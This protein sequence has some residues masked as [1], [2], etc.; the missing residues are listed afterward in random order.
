MVFLEGIICPGNLIYFKFY[1]LIVE[2]Q[3][4][5]LYLTE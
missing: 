4:D 2:D 3:A 1:H 5:V